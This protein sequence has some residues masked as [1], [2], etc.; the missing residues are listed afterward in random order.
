MRY[1][2]F[3]GIL[4]LILVKFCFPKSKENFTNSSVVRL[5]TLS[6][7]EST[8]IKSTIHNQLRNFPSFKK[9]LKQIKIL[10]TFNYK[11][12]G[13]DY[14]VHVLASFPDNENIERIKVHIDSQYTIKDV[15]E[16]KQVKFFTGM[17]APTRD[18]VPET[19]P[20]LVQK[21][22]AFSDVNFRFML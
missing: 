10:D 9:P 21:N 8:Q 3:F 22:H 17:G 2:L 19:I 1:Y 16:D 6:E 15:T 11:R 12:D 7:S 14:R 4:V 13:E 5:Q 20:N 18:P